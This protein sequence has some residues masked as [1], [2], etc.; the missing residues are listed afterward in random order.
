M[1]PRERLLALA[2]GEI[3][4]DEAAAVE[5]HVL[6]CSTCA[7]DLERLLD[8]RNAIP[9]LVRAGKVRVTVTPALLERLE[10]EGLVTRTYEIAPNQ[11]V[12]C[13]VGATDV[14]TAVHLLGLDL[15]GVTRV[16]L[17]VSLHPHEVRFEDVVFDAAHGR[18]VYAQRADFIR[19][20]ATGRHG[21]RLV[22]VEA[23]GDR[24]LARYHL[25]H[26]AYVG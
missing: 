15:A 14:Y 4:G 13:T 26:T 20:L 6:G 21:I 7:A 5:D 12:S 17:I 25:D 1:I 24:E 19:T 2:L 23:G 8:L 9:A 18:V 22:S 11:A 3:E 16:D 10:R